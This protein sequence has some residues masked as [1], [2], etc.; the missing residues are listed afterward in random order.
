MNSNEQDNGVREESGGKM[1]S[2]VV[3]WIGLITVA[4]LVFV[5]A[6]CLRP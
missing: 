4:A 2:T 5:G 1:R 6:Y 3:A